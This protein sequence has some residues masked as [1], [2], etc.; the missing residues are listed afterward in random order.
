MPEGTPLLGLL[1]FVVYWLGSEGGPRQT[2]C[3]CTNCGDLFTGFDS[4]L[5]HECCLKAVPLA[6]G[7]K[8]RKWTHFFPAGVR[9][10]DK[11]AHASSD[12]SIFRA[13]VSEAT[14][15]KICARV[16][17]ALLRKAKEG[18]SQCTACGYVHDATTKKLRHCVSHGKV[19]P[20]LPPS[21]PS[22]VVR[23]CMLYLPR[24]ATRPG[25]E[26]TE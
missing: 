25:T 4:V 8:Q 6:E 16:S 1:D 23:T 24:L 7:Q 17:G 22:L 2:S 15:R 18:E 10:L 20:S 5:R 21:C 3:L 9:A 12:R 26:S 19:L 14:G 13:S 11:V